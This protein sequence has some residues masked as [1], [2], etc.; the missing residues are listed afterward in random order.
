MFRV[1][2][3]W[4]FSFLLFGCSG[5]NFL[6]QA[7][8]LQVHSLG[9]QKL[10]L[11]CSCQITACMPTTATE[12]EIWA[13]DIPLDLLKSGNFESGQIIRFQVLWLPSPGK[14]PLAS[15]S[16]NISIKQIIIS[17]DEVGIYIG[18]GYGWPSGSPEDG[19]SITMEDA[20]IQLQSSTPR[21]KDL[22]TPATMIGFI[23][24]EANTP[25]ARQIAAFANRYTN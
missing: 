19:L 24:A 8:T 7:Q 9:P 22:L 21:F 20:T 23:H 10:L 16:T 3:A 5:S 18:A 6:G 1:S 13:T 15:T 14:T 12:G 11:D 17:G 4:I 2:I 25:L